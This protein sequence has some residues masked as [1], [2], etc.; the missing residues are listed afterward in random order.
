MSDNGSLRELAKV[1]N[2]LL[3]EH[4]GFVLPR[5]KEAIEVEVK[6]GIEK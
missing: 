4:Y 3:R 2:P 6:R 5:L 1:A